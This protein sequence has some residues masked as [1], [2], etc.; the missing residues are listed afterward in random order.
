MAKKTEK[1]LYIVL[2]EANSIEG[3]YEY[4]E[5]ACEQVGEDYQILEVVKVWSCKYEAKLTDQKLKFDI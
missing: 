2:D 1:K 5:S 3:Q 4:L